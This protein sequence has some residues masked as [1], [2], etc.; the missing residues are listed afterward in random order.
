[1]IDV[2]QMATTIQQ[3]LRQACELRRLSPEALA[4]AAGLSRGYIS[5]II[6]DPSRSG[7][8]ADEAYRIAFEAQISLSYL[9]YGTGSI[10]GPD[11][12]K[13]P[14]PPRPGQQRRIVD[15]PRWQDIALAAI[16][17]EPTLD[18]A[19]MGAGEAAAVPAEELSV[20]SLLH[21]AER[22]RRSCSDTEER[23]R[24]DEK[25]RAFIKLHRA[26]TGESAKKR[27][28]SQPPKR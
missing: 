18:W 15:D 11:V 12:P 28:G 6:A 2:G 9:L 16:E 3:R 24:L 8:G 27:S 21:A 10:L 22:F 7:L 4:L 17:K 20:Y 1:M 25:A 19:I 26:R 5:R 23:A 13:E 14:P